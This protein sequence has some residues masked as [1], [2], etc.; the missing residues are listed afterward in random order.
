MK[1]KVTVISGTPTRENLKN[2]YNVCY[3]LFNAQECY[4]S[5]K[6]IEQLKQNNSNIF[7]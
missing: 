7:L 5:P 4:Y 3:K 1:A 6:E 2:V